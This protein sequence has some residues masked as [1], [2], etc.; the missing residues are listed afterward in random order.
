MQSVADFQN[1]A[2]E[3]LRYSESIHCRHEDDCQR[4]VLMRNTLVQWL[5]DGS[6]VP[7]HRVAKAID[8]LM[9]IQ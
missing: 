8:W 3:A 7:I 1:Q 5:E 4:T 9:R 6:S 2:K